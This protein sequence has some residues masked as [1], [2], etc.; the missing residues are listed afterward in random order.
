LVGDFYQ[1]LPLLGIASWDTADGP[2]RNRLGTIARLTTVLA[3]YETVTRRS[4]ADSANPGEQVAGQFGD[5]WFY[6]NLATLLTNYANGNYDDF[7]GEQDLTADALSLGTVHGAKGLEWPLVFLPSLSAKRFPSSKVGQAQDWLLPR[8]LFDVVRYEGTD[9]DE[10]RLFYV[11]VTRA[12]DW[13]SL[14]THQQVTPGSQ[15]ASKTSPYLDE[16]KWYADTGG[17]PTGADPIGLEAPDLAITYSALDAYLTCP[18]SYLLRNEL[19]FMPPMRAEIG[20]GNAVHHIMRLVAE[21]TQSSGR[22]PTTPEI[23]A[24]LSQGFFLPFANKAAHKEMR[25]KAE[26]LVQRYIT[27]HSDDLLRTWATEHPFELYLPG[28]VVSGRPDVVYDDHDGVPANLAIV[29]YKTST[30]GIVKPL[31]LQVYADAGRSRHDVPIDDASVALA[32]QTVTTAAEALTQRDFTPAP[33]K[34]KCRACDVRSICG[35]A[36]VA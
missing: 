31:Q 18:Q 19:G 13:V 36:V 21:H 12:R 35:A 4:R 6:F 14:S 23:D 10:R 3:D 7:D 5:R 27:N 1:L 29:D 20:Y 8:H 26:R 22:V 33:E 28:V 2:T 30:H 15:Q 25:S 24:L 17:T 32:E 34:T 16:V 9:A 11:A